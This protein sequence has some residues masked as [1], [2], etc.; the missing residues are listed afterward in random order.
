HYLLSNYRFSFIPFLFLLRTVDRE[1]SH[2]RRPENAEC[3]N[4]RKETQKKLNKRL[5]EENSNRL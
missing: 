1:I 5:F 3:P 2:S 4:D